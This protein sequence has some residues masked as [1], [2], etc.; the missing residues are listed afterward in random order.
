MVVVLKDIY[1]NRGKD[2]VFMFFENDVKLSSEVG[3]S[4]L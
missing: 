4:L 2:K 1:M 3:G